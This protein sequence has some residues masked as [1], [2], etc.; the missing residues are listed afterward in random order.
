MQ[1]HNL[2]ILAAFLLFGLG[3]ILGLPAFVA[4]PALLG[5]PFGLL[6]IYQMRRISDGFK[7]NWT[8]LTLV[9]VA[10]F[11]FTTYLVTFSYWTH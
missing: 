1:L 11:T 6:Q 4:L 7:P 3:L 9:S 5:L 8:A 2:L 10:L